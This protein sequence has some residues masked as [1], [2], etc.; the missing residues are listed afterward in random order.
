MRSFGVLSMRQ[1]RIP[2]L[3]LLSAL[4]LLQSSLPVRAQDA[5]PL[6]SLEAVYTP[7]LSSPT[8]GA[9][10]P[11]F[12]PGTFVYDARVPFR[13]Q[14]VRF[15]LG[16]NDTLLAATTTSGGTAPQVKAKWNEGNEF[17][18]TLGQDT[19][20]LKLDNPSG[21]H[22]LEVNVSPVPAGWGAADGTDS[23]TYFVSVS[24]ALLESH[25]AAL[26][27][28]A[29]VEEDGSGADEQGDL[30]A[31]MAP[32]AT[33]S[34]QVFGYAVRLAPGLNT[35]RF[36]ATVDAQASVAYRTTRTV[37][38]PPETS[39]AP[40][41]L[42]Q[43]APGSSGSS[44]SGASARSEPIVVSPGTRQRVDVFVVAEDG[45]TARNYSFVLGAHEDTLP[46]V[47][48]AEGL[49][50]YVIGGRDRDSSTGDGMDDLGAAP[51]TLSSSALW[52]AAL[53]AM[54]AA[55]GLQ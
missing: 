46:V 15:R 35:V 42:V 43:L 32:Q 45:Y 4:L 39:D 22:S 3:L 28:L 9:L 52:V 41:E 50:E 12:A 33:F 54:L 13:T 10:D 47:P 51:A 36:E 34:S 24:R 49:G 17:E 38:G 16:L 20:E 30:L 29:W 19:Q 14:S 26:I 21:L 2:L 1:W 27:S 40:S 48:A 6:S 7:A 31:D 5:G 8:S 25:N 18:V 53:L 37:V 44:S 23:V 11:A 55:F